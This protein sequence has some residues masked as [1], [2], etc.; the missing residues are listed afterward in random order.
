MLR[1]G[2]DLGGTKIAAGLVDE[3]RNLGASVQEPTRLPRPAK[4]LAE[5]VFHL[6]ERLLKEQGIAWEQVECVGIGI[7]GTVNRETDCV[8]YANNF[9]FENVPFVKMVKV[10]VYQRYKI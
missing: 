9:G 4:E 7:P 10:F 3:G 1:I 6:A 8:E 2:I 5:A